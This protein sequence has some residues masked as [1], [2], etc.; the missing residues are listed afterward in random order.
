MALDG[1]QMM[2]KHTTAN[3]KHSSATEEWYNMRHD[4][5]G[6][7]GEQTVIVVGALEFGWC[8]K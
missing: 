1:G 8:K 5:E 6:M 7:W 3:Q 4:R 2:N